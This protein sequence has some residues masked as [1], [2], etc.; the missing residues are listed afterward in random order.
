MMLD[1]CFTACPYLPDACIPWPQDEHEAHVIVVIRLVAWTLG[2]ILMLWRHR[3]LQA[4]LEE[5]E[6]SAEEISANQKS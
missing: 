3:Q 1:H 6:R 2:L 5:E 4:Q